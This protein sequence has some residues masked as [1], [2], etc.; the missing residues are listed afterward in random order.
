[1]TYDPSNT[2]RDELLELKLPALIAGELSEAEAAGLRMAINADEALAAEYEELLSA[3]S[4]LGMALKHEPTQPLTNTQ[5]E[6]ILKAAETGEERL[7]A[8]ESAARSRTFHFPCGDGGRKWQWWLSVAASIVVCI[9]AAQFL[10]M[11]GSATRPKPIPGPVATTPDGEQT[12]EGYHGT[13][14]P[15]EGDTIWI[16]PGMMPDTTEPHLASAPREGYVPLEIKLPSRRSDGTP[17]LIS[18]NEPNM[19]ERKPRDYRRPQFYVPKGTINV[20]LTTTVTA[21]EE[22]MI[23]ELSQIVDGIAESDDENILD[24]DSGPVWVTLDLGKSCE[25]FAIVMWHRDRGE[26]EIAMRDVIVETA[27]DKDFTINHYILFNN[28]HDGSLNKGHPKGTD[29]QYIETHEGKLVDALAV[30]ARY[31]RFWS[32]GN[33]VDDCTYW[34]EIKIFGKDIPTSTTPGLNPLAMIVSRALR[35]HLAS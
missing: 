4:L 30:K 31:V 5:I 1:M 23:G 7:D 27:D 11:L 16:D 2:P 22:P 10:M 17:C 34:S 33:T 15:L 13:P 29:Q 35:A 28:D 14:A 20:A 21:S 32:N 18:R 12:P 24:L 26:V 8:L 6:A 25:L 19:E 3:T 9:V